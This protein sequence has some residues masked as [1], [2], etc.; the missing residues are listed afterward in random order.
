MKLKMQ[1]AY[2]L[3]AILF[4]GC[5]AGREFDCKSLDE[6]QEKPLIT[7]DVT[8]KMSAWQPIPIDAPD[9]KILIDG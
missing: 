5:T 1:K 4:V 2:I 3:Q 6:I 9:S 7:M 8:N